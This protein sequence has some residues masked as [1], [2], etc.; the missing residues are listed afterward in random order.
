MKKIV[1]GSIFILHSYCYT[2]NNIKIQF[3]SRHE[4]TCF[5]AYVKIKTQ[6][7]CAVTAQLISTFLF[8]TQIEQSL[9]YLNKKFPASSQ[10]LWLYSL[11]CVEPGR[12]PRRPVFSRCG[13]FSLTKGKLTMWR[14]HPA[15]IMIT[16]ESLHC[17]HEESLGLIFFNTWFTDS[18]S[19]Y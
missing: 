3:E 12:K 1:F 18:F 14:F 17:P 8:V 7:S 4:K 6:I 13:S 9:F 10:L 16:D 5:F 11:V 19:K 2:A 15:K